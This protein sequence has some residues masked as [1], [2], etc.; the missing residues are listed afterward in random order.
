V[1]ATSPAAT[2][3]VLLAGDDPLLFGET[4]R[5]RNRRVVERVGATLVDSASGAELSASRTPDATAVVRVP[6]NVAI[7][8][9]LFPLEIPGPI[10]VTPGMG[11]TADGAMDLSTPAARRRA[12]WAIVRRTAKASDGWVSRHFNRPISR[13]L[14]IVML[15]LGLRAWHASLVTLLFGLA[16]AV[17]AASPGYAAFALVGVMFHAASVL[18]GVDGEMARATLTESE[19]GARIDTLV[20][21]ATYVACFVGL[22][23]GWVREAGAGVVVTWTVAVTAGLLLT[24]ARGGRFVARYAPNASFVFIDRAVRRAARDTG[25]N[26]LKVAAAAFTLLRRD[27]FAVIFMVVG[28]AGVR[29]LVPALVAAGVVVANLTFSIYRRELAAAA[30]AERG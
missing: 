19:A 9:W 22:A 24:L 27:V 20:D 25:K 2:T 5:A 21:Q 26:G 13:L 16:A 29:A 11:A 18:D 30:I 17:I 15:S 6:A 4:I 8:T 28:F 12:A 7:N 1:N 23:I 10:I 14:S 3:V